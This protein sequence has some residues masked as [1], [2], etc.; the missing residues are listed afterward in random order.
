M[1]PVDILSKLPKDFYEKLEAKKWQDRKEALDA[2]E[3]LLKAA[4]KL[5]Q[6]DYGD[7]ARAMKKV[8]FLRRIHFKII[9]TKHNITLIFFYSR[10]YRKI[11]MY[12]SSLWLVV[13]FV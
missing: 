1:D 8:H 3:S 6:G 10:L 7:I 4:P 9:Q 11:P 2:L 12:Y 13:A 5:E